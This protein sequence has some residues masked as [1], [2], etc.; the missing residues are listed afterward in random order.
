M[1]M[2]APTADPRIVVMEWGY[3]DT[4][5]TKFSV[6]GGNIKDVC[7]ATTKGRCKVLRSD[8]YADYTGDIRTELFE[9][10]VFD[11]EDAETGETGETGETDE[12]NGNETTTR[13]TKRIAFADYVTNITKYIPDLKIKGES[14][15]TE[16]DHVLLMSPQTCVLPA[17]E[18]E[19]VEFWCETRNYDHGEPDT[20]AILAEANS[21]SPLLLKGSSSKLYMLQDGKCHTFKA[22]RL[23]DERIKEAM[24]LEGGKSENARTGKMTEN[25]KKC[26]FFRKMQK[27]MHF[28]K[29]YASTCTPRNI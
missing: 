19:A 9:V 24:A 14:L 16:R 7:L 22:T 21:T 1:D 8:N 27:K 18:N 20:L 26:I 5:R 2:S 6:C 10:T 29:N 15:L 28:N 4:K 12:N 3:F 25:E 23:K 11:D 17:G 13:K